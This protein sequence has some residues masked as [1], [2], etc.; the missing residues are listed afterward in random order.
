MFFTKDVRVDAKLNKFIWSQGVRNIPVR[1]RVRLSRKRNEDEEA[2]EKVRIDLVSIEDS[3]LTVSRSYTHL[4]NTS[5]FPLTRD[6]KR[7]MLM[8][9]QRLVYFLN[10]HQKRFIK[11]LF[12]LF[13]SSLSGV[14]A[15]LYKISRKGAP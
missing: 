4:F 9:K 11:S 2:K 14:L 3:Q 13:T 5:K 6:F 1:V 12:S 15:I 10:K 7:K 8:N